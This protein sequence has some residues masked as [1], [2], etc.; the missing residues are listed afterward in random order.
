[1]SRLI[2]QLQIRFLQLTP[3]M[4]FGV[5]ALVAIFGFLIWDATVRPAYAD[6]QDQVAD[7]Q[8][9]IEKLR[10]DRRLRNDIRSVSPAIRTLGRIELPGSDDA[11][12]RKL[13]DLVHRVIGEF[14]S[15]IAEFEFQQR[16]GQKLRP[17]AMSRL[18]GPDEDILRFEGTVRFET[19]PE[20]AMEIIARF[21]ASP[22]LEAITKVSIDKVGNKKVRVNLSLEA[23]AVVSQSGRRRA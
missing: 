14:A 19:S 8:Q 17:L 4:R 18:L 2:E 9:D 23:W 13:Q 16:P 22:D 10:Q 7:V 15:D 11:E 5:V 1:M 21:E 20:R 6:V 12:T 3:V